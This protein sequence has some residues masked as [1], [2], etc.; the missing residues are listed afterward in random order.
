VTRDRDTDALTGDVTRRILKLPPSEGDVL[1]LGAKMT[2]KTDLVKKR[3]PDASY[4]DFS[5]LDTQ[6]RYMVDPSRLL[7]DCD[8][9]GAGDVVILD[10]VQKMPFMME[11]I[12]SLISSNHLRVI[13]CASDRAWLGKC[14]VPIPEGMFSQARI[15]PLVYW[16]TLFILKRAIDCGMIPHCYLAGERKKGLQKYIN[17]YIDK[18]HSESLVRDVASFYRFLE[19]MAK[20]DGL[21][22]NNAAI[23]KDCGI[24]PSTVKS[25]IKVLEDTFIGYTIPSYRPPGSKGVVSSP[26]FMYFDVGLLNQLL[27]RRIYLYK[28]FKSDHYQAFAHLVMQEIIARSSYSRS[29]S[30][31]AVSYW[32]SSKGDYEVDAVIGEA[33]IAISIMCTGNVQYHHVRGLRAFKEQYPD[34]AAYLVIYQGQERDYYGINVVPVINFLNLLWGGKL[35]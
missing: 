15:F 1:L 5:S 9:L 33:R 26:K 3:F 30:D 22:L 28:S 7:F 8:G 6:S 16:E 20:R 32:R 24:S 2:G 29:S 25:Y 34:A 13:L 35:F 18:V 21:P 4:F 19:A 17:L 11:T 14:E 23:A 12:S 31:K 10:E 27:G